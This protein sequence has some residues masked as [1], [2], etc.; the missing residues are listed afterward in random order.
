MTVPFGSEMLS[1]PQG[2]LRGCYKKNMLVQNMSSFR[3]RVRSGLSLIWVVTTK[4]AFLSDEGS[5]NKSMALRLAL[6]ETCLQL[7]K[8][9]VKLCVGLPHLVVWV[10][11]VVVGENLMICYTSQNTVTTAGE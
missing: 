3:M 5:G 6:I 8:K 2:F 11:K 9:S 4:L 1:S 10:V 7:Q